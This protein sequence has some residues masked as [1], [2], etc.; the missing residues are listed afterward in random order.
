[1]PRPVIGSGAVF[2]V[3]PFDRA[4][5]NLGIQSDAREYMKD[6]D[7]KRAQV[8]MFVSGLIILIAIVI[9]GWLIL[10][11]SSVTAGE[12]KEATNLLRGIGNTVAPH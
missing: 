2:T 7:V 6:S 9:A 5:L 4:F 11:Y 1:M 8:W 10:K 3:D 12:I